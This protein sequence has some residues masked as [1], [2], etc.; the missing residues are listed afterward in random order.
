[1]NTPFI[2]DPVVIDPVSVPHPFPPPWACAFGDDEYGLWADFEVMAGAQAVSQRM[3]WIAPGSFTMGLP[4][5]ETAGLGHEEWFARERPRHLVTISHGFW[6]ADTAC[7]QACWQ[8]VMGDNPSRFDAVNKGGAAH[9][10]ERVSWLMIQTFLQQLQALLPA[11]RAT[12][13]TEAEWEY[14]C[15]AGTQTP[16]SFGDTI[17]TAQV[18]YDGN[19]PYGKGKKGEY[20]EHTVAVKALPANAWG[21]YQMHGNVWEWC[22]DTPREYGLEAVLD[23]GLADALAV[24]L[25]SEAV[26]ALR[27]GG[28]F[29]D[30]LYA[31]SASRN[32]YAPDGQDDL[33]G[34]RLALRSSSQ[35]SGF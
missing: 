23:P 29:N 8:A 9:P 12:L 19:Y 31:R 2:S 33:A 11:C 27:G 13:P 3:R 32:R 6:L 28:W 20:R 18:N 24:P 17:S 4:E 15:R 21:G 7:T 26:R 34:F 5:A 25:D 35:A 1:M 14:A 10:V 22:A 16:F 30:A